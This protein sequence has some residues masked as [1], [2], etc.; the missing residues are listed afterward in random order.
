MRVRTTTSTTG[1][2]AHHPGHT[3]DRT[4]RMKSGT[5]VERGQT[6]LACA[7]LSRGAASS[8][9]QRTIAAVTFMART[10]LETIDTSVI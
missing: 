7:R 8:P 1:T 3:R 6:L 5:M 2:S 10:P 4:A 9:A